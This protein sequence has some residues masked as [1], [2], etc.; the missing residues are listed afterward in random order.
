MVPEEIICKDVRQQRFGSP[1]GKLSLISFP[2]STTPSCEKL[3]K[4]CV[5][6]IAWS[7]CVLRDNTFSTCSWFKTYL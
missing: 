5:P 6:E 1:A 2:L 7:L 4:T 3:V